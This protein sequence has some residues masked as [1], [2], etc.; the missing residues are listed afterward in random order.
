MSQKLKALGMLLMLAILLPGCGKVQETAG[1][2]STPY[3][4]GP[5]EKLSEVYQ[6]DRIMDL[7]TIKVRIVNVGIVK[8]LNAPEDLQGQIALG[9]EVANTGDETVKFFPEQITIALET[10]EELVP[11][12]DISSDLGGTFP[13]RRV[14]QGFMLFQLKKS[15]PEQVT[16]L[17]LTLPAPQDEQYRPLGEAKAVDVQLDGLQTA[18]RLLP[19]E[20]K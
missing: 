2:A 18:G 9:L 14:V 4:I 15:R 16:R 7:G 10:G 8:F 3:K 20:N 11:D 5:E 17:E 6:L 19:D 13:A 12:L 1:S